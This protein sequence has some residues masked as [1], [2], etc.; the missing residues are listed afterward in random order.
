MLAGAA[1]AARQSMESPSKLARRELL[2]VAK[3]KRRAREARGGGGGGGPATVPAERLSTAV[4]CL[5]DDVTRQEPKRTY[6]K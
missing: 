5:R 3:A 2:E 6:V 1:A 4:R